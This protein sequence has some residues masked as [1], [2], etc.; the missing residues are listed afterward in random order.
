MRAGVFAVVAVALVLALRAQSDGPR[1]ALAIVACVT[2]VL[3]VAV[4]P[5][6]VNERGL[7]AVVAGLVGVQ[8][9]LHVGFLYASTGHFAHPGAAGL[10]CSPSGP[11]ATGAVSCL[12]THRG[13]VLLFCVQLLAAVGFAAWRRGLDR[14]VWNIARTALGN[15]GAATHRCAGVLASALEPVLPA[16]ATSCPPARRAR[17]LPS[18]PLLTREHGR[19]GPPALAGSCESAVHSARPLALVF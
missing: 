11:H 6:T 8:Q 14:S 10:L 18:S 4:R 3:A 17:P 1:P 7:G 13:G 2:V 5:L 12:P 19:R 16:R 15:L 9:V